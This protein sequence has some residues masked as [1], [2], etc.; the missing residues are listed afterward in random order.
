MLV[1]VNSKQVL[2]AKFKAADIGLDM[3]KLYY[4]GVTASSQISGQAGT[5]GGNL[6]IEKFSLMKQK[7]TSLKISGPYDFKDLGTSPVTSQ[8]FKIRID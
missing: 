4:I 7:P 3:N 2:S 5:R 6:A 1:N 8:T